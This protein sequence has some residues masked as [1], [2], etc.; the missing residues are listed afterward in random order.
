MKICPIASWFLKW[1]RRPAL[2]DDQRALLEVQV[3][4]SHLVYGMGMGFAELAQRRGVPYILGEKTALQT[5]IV[6][7]TTQVSSRLRKLV[8][9]ARTSRGYRCPGGWR[10]VDGLA[11]G[12]EGRPMLAA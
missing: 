5:R 3:A 6:V 4:Q 7:A 9:A 11:T 8:R 12:C 1:I 10:T 2:L